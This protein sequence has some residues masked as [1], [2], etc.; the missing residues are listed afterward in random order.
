MLLSKTQ[1][2]QSALWKLEISGLPKSEFISYTTAFQDSVAVI[3]EINRV[4][5]ALTSKGYFYAI[6]DQK[7]WEKRFCK[8]H[9]EIGQP[10]KILDITNGN[11]AAAALYDTK[12]REKAYNNIHFDLIQLQQ[13]KENLVHWYENNGYPFAKIWLDSFQLHQNALSVKLYAEPGDKIYIDTIKIVGSASV[14]TSFLSSHISIKQGDIYNEDKVKRIDDRL[15][16]L[17]YLK[18]V[19]KKQIDFIGDKAHLN[20]F[21][22]KEGANQFDGLI[23]FLPNQTTGK[24]Q[25]SGDFKLKLQNVF[26]AGESLAFN[27]RGLP[28]QVQELD[29]SA[30]YP[31]LFGTQLGIKGDLAFF[32]QDT[33]YLNLNTKFSFVYNYSPQRSVSFFVENFNGTKLAEQNLG[34][35]PL[36]DINTLFYGVESELY[37]VDNGLM[38]LKGYKLYAYFG[39]GNR[40]ATEEIIAQ[41]ERLLVKSS[42][43]KVKTD[44]NYYLKVS[45][46]SVLYLHNLS[47]LLTGKDLYEN[48]IFRIGGS[49]TLRG[50]DEQQFKVSSFSV[51]TVEYRHYIESASY[52]N[53]FY[54]QA[55]LKQLTLN[56]SKTILPFSFGVGATF[57][58]KVGLLSFNYALGKQ[59]NIPLDLQ[60]GKIHF[61]IVSY[62]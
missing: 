25:M 15:S 45:K 26:K 59:Q 21:I 10:Y 22:D 44:L 3:D 51:Q 13:L 14:N 33:T 29:L 57:S 46:I 9:F 60:K 38:P 49:K 39:A 28:Q 48:E 30:K 61:G 55:F 27:Y 20:I 11:V 16:Q 23:G 5:D 62:F 50:F 35:T 52:V 54:E 56:E 18:V 8:I 6:V 37:K 4:Y 58:T 31:Y 42:Q 19:K 12:F 53:V 32:K 40:R 41:P 1:Y 36:A 43:F 2:A 24:L 17:P 47:A 34:D 7:T